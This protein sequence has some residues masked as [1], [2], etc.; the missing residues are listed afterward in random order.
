MS[1]HDI[2]LFKEE[3]VILILVVEAVDALLPLLKVCL[4]LIKQNRCNLHSVV[5]RINFALMVVLNL[6]DNSAHAIRDI[7]KILVDQ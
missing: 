5:E 1:I 7:H 2:S 4:V 6:I 3:S